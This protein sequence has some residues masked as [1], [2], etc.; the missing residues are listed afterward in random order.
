M[1]PFTC[2]ANLQ[3]VTPDTQRYVHREAAV[4][5]RLGT[6]HQNHI[7][8]YID[9]FEVGSKSWLC[10]WIFLAVSKIFDRWISHQSFGQKF[11]LPNSY[12]M[13][14]PGVL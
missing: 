5:R 9:Y 8:N 10:H 1:F 3:W 14:W 4:L 11:A 2:S 6:G 7:V 13:Q 12:Y